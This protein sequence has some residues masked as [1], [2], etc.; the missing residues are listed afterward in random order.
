MMANSMTTNAKRTFMDT[1]L[2]L[3]Y[4]LFFASAFVLGLARTDGAEAMDSSY[5]ADP[6]CHP[7]SFL[8]EFFDGVTPPALPAGWSS[9]TWATSNSGVPMPPR[10]HSPMPRL[11]MI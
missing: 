7:H 10:I 11:W 5:Q 1:R 8:T 6:P 4:C 3:L 2:R 9:T